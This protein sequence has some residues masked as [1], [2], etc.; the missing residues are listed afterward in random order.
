M[1]ERRKVKRDKEM[2]EGMAK[3]KTNNMKGNTG[4]G[5]EI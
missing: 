4:R 5:K 1:K 2:T 3:E